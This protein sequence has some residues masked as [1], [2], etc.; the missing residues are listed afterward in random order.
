MA[1]CEGDIGGVESEGGDDTMRVIGSLGLIVI[2]MSG[3]IW[4]DEKDDLKLCGPYSLLMAC[5]ILGVKADLKQIAQPA[6]TTDEGTTMKELADAAYKLGL[7][8]RGMKI[9][10]K[11][12]TK[13]KTPFIA[14]VRGNHFLVVEKVIGD[15]VRILDY[16]RA[17]YMMPISEFRKIWKGYILELSNPKNPKNPQPDIHPDHL[18]YDF[19]TAPQYTTVRHAFVIK[20]I[21][22]KPLLV[23]KIKPSCNCTSATISSKSIPPDGEA[24]LEVLFYT[25]NYVGQQ[26]VTVRLYTNDPDEPVILLTVKGIVLIPE[27]PVIPREI[28]LGKIDGKEEIT[29]I[30]EVYDP[31]DKRLE[32]KRVRSSSDK[33]KV[34]IISRKKGESAV[35]QVQIKPGFARGGVQ[36][37]DHDSDK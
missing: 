13:V 37:T 21:G 28:E 16:G 7:Q 17:P 27:I 26:F 24:R 9:P 36:G 29:R 8:A 30:V 15:Q 6:G 4:S 3:S 5:Q 34:R 23:T 1:P 22:A 25:S 32:V 10:P 20:N 14:H 11:M 12:I 19:G 33:V 18:V 2:L 31:G 35:I